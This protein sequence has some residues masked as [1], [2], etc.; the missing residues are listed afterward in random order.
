MKAPSVTQLLP[1]MLGV[2]E[3]EIDSDIKNRKQL[4]DMSI[5]NETFNVV[6]T[7]EANTLENS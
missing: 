3:F 4:E 5:F 1:A 7:I 6:N 2:R